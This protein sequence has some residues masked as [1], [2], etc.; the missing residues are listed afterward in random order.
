MEKLFTGSYSIFRTTPANGHPVLQGVP[1][2][3]TAACG[4]KDR[5]EVLPD[6]MVNHLRSIR[7][8]YSFMTF[9]GS[10]FNLV[11]FHPE[12]WRKDDNLVRVDHY[13]QRYGLSE[14]EF[15]RQLGMYQDA[16]ESKGILANFVDVVRNNNS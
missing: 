9:P 2:R 7:C 4:R 15:T 6:G 11:Q 5:A 1:K 12:L 16:P 14:A 3:F 10:N 13:K 8:K